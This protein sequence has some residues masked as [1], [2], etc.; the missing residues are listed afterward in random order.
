MGHGQS[1]AF[2]SHAFI[3]NFLSAQQEAGPII[4]PARWDRRCDGPDNKRCPHGFHTPPG[5][6]GRVETIPLR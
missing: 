2:F 1:Q 3:A 4:P 5:H 6:P